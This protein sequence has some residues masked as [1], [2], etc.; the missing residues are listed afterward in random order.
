MK[1]AV[2]VL[3]HQLF[4]KHPLLNKPCLT[5]LAE[6]DYFFNRY[7]FHKQKI[8]LHHASMHYYYDHLKKLGYDVIYCSHQE[9]PS[10]ATLISRIKDDGITEIGALELI[11]HELASEFELATKK[12][13]IASSIVKSPMFLTSEKL[14]SSFFN[15]KVK[16]FVMG[17]FYREQ[18]KELNILLNKK[19]E[20]IGG[21]W[22]FDKLNREPLPE[23]INVPKPYKP[24]STTYSKAA[25]KYVEKY[26]NEN[27]GESDCRY[28]ITHKQAEVALD[29]FL[30]KRLKNF[31][32]YQDALSRTSAVLF[33]SQL[34]PALNIGLLTPKRIINKT[35]SYA[36][37]HKVP[38]NS[39]EGF[40]RQIIGWREFVYGMYRF[41][42][43]EQKESNFWNNKKSLWDGWWKA[44]TGIIPVDLTIK[45][46][47]ESAYAHHIER[48]MILGN[49]M[50][51][52]QIKPDE[53]YR[54]F[55]ELFI[56]SY[57]W[58]M[59]PNVYGMSQFADG[60]LMATKPYISSSSYIQKM[61]SYEKGEWEQIWNALFWNFMNTHRKK[62]KKN[63]RS[64]R[65]VSLLNKMKK[66]TIQNYVKR[67]K[68][69]LSMH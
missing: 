65:T 69:Y 52:C 28:P 37:N 31:G 66:K 22:S 3:P 35:L 10:I 44:S 57:D 12:Y 62:M 59:I 30:K 9:C 40:I 39:L 6:L 2:I 49:F 60:G 16:R 54:W 34:S 53:V 43:P 26:Y 7:H 23:H 41:H 5:Y 64:A 19:G 18:R 38:L 33:H 11:E 32:P 27:P 67:S 1:K 15:R 8:A 46:V 25:C 68:K 14:L 21:Q 51:L 47:L 58:V 42:G 63:A 48:L 56:D 29:N 50:L 17:Y 4:I 24:R 20:P 55:M 61:G 36:K 45:Q 13:N